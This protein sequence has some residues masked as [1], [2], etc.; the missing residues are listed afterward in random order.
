MPEV[1]GESRILHK[2]EI[3]V[4]INAPKVQIP[5]S[6]HNANT[7]I[8]MTTHVGIIMIQPIKQVW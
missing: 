7:L 3:N 8:H 1:A 4:Y 6:E 5:Q 2:K